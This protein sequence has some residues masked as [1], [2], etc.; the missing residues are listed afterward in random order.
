MSKPFVDVELNVF[1][2]YCKI[3]ESVDPMKRVCL[4]VEQAA[5]LRD[6]LNEWLPYFQDEKNF[7]YAREFLE[8]LKGEEKHEG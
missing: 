8:K 1:R 6:R 2:D 4:T 3:S 5:F 7:Q